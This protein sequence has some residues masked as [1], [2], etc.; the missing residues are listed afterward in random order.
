LPTARNRYA[1]E[2]FRQGGI[3]CRACHGDPAAHLAN[4]GH[5]PIVNP[6]KLSVP[7]RDSVCLQCHLEGDFAVY[8]ADRSPAHFR[9]GD[10]LADYVV[11]FVRASEQAGGFRGTSQYEALQ[12]SACKRRSG[13]RL[14]CTTCHDPHSRPSSA[15]RVQYFRSRCL[16]CHAQPAIARTHHPEQPECA[17]CHMPS[18]NTADIPHEQVTDHNIQ[19]RPSRPSAA[20]LFLT[21]TDQLVPVGNVRPG[22]REL[23][24]AYAQLAQR[25]DR[26][27][28][29]LAIRLLSSAEKTA[30][31]DVQMKVQLGFLKQIS[32]QLD[33][34]RADYTDALL[35]NP[36]EP[37]ALANLAVI[38]A[39]GGQVSEAVRLLDRLTSADPS[40]T[41]A[42]LNLAFIEC[43]L[44]RQ[45]DALVL[46]RRLLVFNPDDPQLREFLQSGAYQGHS[47]ALYPR[48]KSP[49]P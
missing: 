33:A 24:L 13:D 41:S 6:A 40:Q 16:T 27:A 47:C 25:G 46:A 26:R 5:G 32:G 3:G 45:A 7:R 29:E 28:A 37:A 4:Q 15:E 9:P 14:T 17:L 20:R 22:S 43:K 49:N 34:A 44:E 48:T 11:H 36:Y 23:G 38:D 31:A 39:G 18:R 2:P 8:R 12:H 35:S 42:G 21:E 10:D 19:A 30:P 1:A